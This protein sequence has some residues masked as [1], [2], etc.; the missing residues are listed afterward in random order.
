MKKVKLRWLVLRLPAEKNA[1][2]NHF[3]SLL[4]II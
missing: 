4:T 2:D 1:V 3:F